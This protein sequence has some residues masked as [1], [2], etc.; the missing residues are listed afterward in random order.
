MNEFEDIANRYKDEIIRLQDDV[1]YCIDE[2][3]QELPMSH[4]N[5]IKILSETLRSSDDNC[6]MI[7]TIEIINSKLKN[8]DQHLEKSE[9]YAILTKEIV[10]QN[11]PKN[12]FGSYIKKD[13]KIS[14]QDKQL[15]EGYCSQINSTIKKANSYLVKCGLYFT[16]KWFL[17]NGYEINKEVDF[18]KEDKCFSVI[19][20]KKKRV[21]NVEV[22]CSAIAL[23]GNSKE[24][25]SSTVIKNLPLQRTYLFDLNKKRK[26]LY[27]FCDYNNSTQILTLYAWIKGQF[28]DKML[29]DPLRERFKGKKGCIVQKCSNLNKNF[30]CSIDE[31]LTER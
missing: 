19:H 6:S 1:Q 24:L 8:K 23:K 16:L 27:V 17:S 3:R 7:E 31:L 12:K 9:K 5:A 10:A 14:D 29:I 4:K 21:Y 18:E 20:K 28:I 2:L 30:P 22:V 26:D 15:I 13:Y 11:K 25:D